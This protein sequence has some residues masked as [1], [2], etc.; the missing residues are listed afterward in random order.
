MP[1]TRP[2]AATRGGTIAT[3]VGVT[4]LAVAVIALSIA[5]L[6]EVRAVAPGGATAQPAPT[7]SFARTPAAS[8]TPT[9][10]PT[11]T[12]SGVA[13]ALGGAGAAER[14]LTVGADAM[15]R[16]TAGTCTPTGQAGGAAG[17][18]PAHVE[19]SAD[20]GQTWQNV[21]PAN[22][23][24]AH[25]RSLTS[26]GGRNATAVVDTGA[27][28]TTTTMRT[29]TDGQF[30]EPYPDIF[31]TDTYLSAT[32][33]VVIE[34][35]T[36]TAP[37]SAPS[38]LRQGGGGVALLC[39]GSAYLRTDGTWT[40]LVGDARA[41]AVSDAGVVVAHADA[42]CPGIRVTDFASASDPVDLGC[43]DADAASPL[44]IDVIPTDGT[45]GDI[46]TIALWT[47][48][49]IITLG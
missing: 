49:R 47:G 30:W 32:G 35:Q 9:P 38:G 17:G 4:I 25:V 19:R 34:G 23:S 8:A 43:A 22:G 18:P 45:G 2:I 6:R 15:W 24:I 16:A 21:T 12:G 5:A 10:T 11:P 46:P 41:L 20:G 26:F 40:P 33:S 42:A 1:R 7:Y 48:D 39:D 28:C 36:V 37:C 13:P 27:A 31:A 14:L 44:A 3:A 29:Y